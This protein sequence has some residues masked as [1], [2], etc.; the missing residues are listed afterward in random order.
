MIILD[1]I[2]PKKN[3]FQVCRQLKTTPSTRNIKIIMLT[4]FTK[5]NMV[6]DALDAGAIG[7]IASGWW[8]EPADWMLGWVYLP[9]FAAIVVAAVLMAPLGVK[10][11][12]RVAP[13]PLR[14]V[15]GCLLI[16]VSI[17][18]LYSAIVV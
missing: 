5:E 7:Y 17:R 3:G 8:V 14:R 9:A 6:Q 15:F 12:H 2:L 13:L 11:A 16:L 18:M 4:S 1:I 10:V